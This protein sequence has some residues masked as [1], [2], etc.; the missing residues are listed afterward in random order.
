MTARRQSRGV[1]SSATGQWYPAGGE[2][3]LIL[4]CGDASAHWFQL[5]LPPA[6]HSDF[7]VRHRSGFEVVCLL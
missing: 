4:C 6:A 5:P 7:P 1:A 3:G 2:P